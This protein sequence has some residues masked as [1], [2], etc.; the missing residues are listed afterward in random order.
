LFVC[1]FVCFF[2]RLFFQ[3]CQ[4]FF[5]SLA[6]SAGHSSSVRVVP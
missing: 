3:H 1:L 6:L 5:F 4:Q 2:V